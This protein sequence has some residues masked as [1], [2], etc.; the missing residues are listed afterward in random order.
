VQAALSRIDRDP[1]IGMRYFNTP[2]RFHRTRTFPYVIY[3]MELEDHVRVMAIAH[4]KRWPG[5]WMRRKPE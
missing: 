4:E 5:Y 3:Y 2:Y 1:K